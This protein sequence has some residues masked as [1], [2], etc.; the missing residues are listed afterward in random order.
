MNMFQ[1]NFRDPR[2]GR[3]KVIHNFM[4]RVVGNEFLIIFVVLNQTNYETPPSSVPLHSFFVYDP[5]NGNHEF[6]TLPP[7]N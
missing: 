4:S 7:Y 3:K 2:G 5:F 1:T 6:I